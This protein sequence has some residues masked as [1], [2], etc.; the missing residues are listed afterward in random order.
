MVNGGEERHYSELMLAIKINYQ[1]LFNKIRCDTCD[2]KTR[3]MNCRIDRNLHTCVLHGLIYH[4]SWR[5]GPIYFR[6][7]SH[8]VHAI[9]DTLCLNKMEFIAVLIVTS[10]LLSTLSLSNIGSSMYPLSV[11]ARNSVG[12]YVLGWFLQ[13]REDNVTLSRSKHNSYFM[14]QRD[15]SIQC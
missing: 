13:I 8:K 4:P 14:N 15:S 10:I 5:P 12:F 6:R 1:E 7:Q 2:V 9:S 3:W 11:I